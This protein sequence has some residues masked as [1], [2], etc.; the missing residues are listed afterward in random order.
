MKLDPTL[1]RLG[2]VLRQR[3]ADIP[4]ADMPHRITALLECLERLERSHR[5]E[6]AEIKSGVG[7]CP[8]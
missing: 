6:H 8:K 4:Q 3:T 5:R 7:S 2:M 1:K